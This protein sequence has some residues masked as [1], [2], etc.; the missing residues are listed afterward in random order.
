M[1]FIVRWTI[2]ILLLIATLAAAS[3]ISNAQLPP[4]CLPYDDVRAA[5]INDGLR[6]F[7]TATVLNGAVP[8]EFWA[9]RETAKWV[10]LSRVGPLGCRVSHGDDFEPVHPPPAPIPGKDS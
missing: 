1:P 10:V 6:L 4:S 7:A 3:R 5:L 9:S 2:G 8:V